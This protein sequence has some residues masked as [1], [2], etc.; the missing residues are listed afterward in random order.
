MKA[1]GYKHPLP[2]EDPDSLLDLEIPELRPSSRDLLVEIKAVSV[3]P[4]DTKVRARVQ[5]ENG[6]YKILGYDAAGVVRGMGPEAKLFKPGDEVWYAGSI[7]RQG[8]NAQLHLVDERIVGPKPRT[9][10]FGASA[11]LPLTT[12][13]AW[14][15]LFD[16]L[17]VQI[18]KPP[19]AGSILIIGGSG[20][21][22]LI[23][24]QLARK[25]IGLTIISTSSAETAQ[26]CLQLGAHFVVDYSRPLAAQLKSIGIPEVNYMACLTASDHYFPGIVEVLAPQGKIGMID[27]PKTLDVVP[28]KA[29]AASLHWEAMFTRSTFQTPDMIAQHNLLTEVSKLVDEGLIHTTLG[30]V[31][32]PINAV[33]LKQA[34]KFVESGRAQGKLVLVGFES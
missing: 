9:L 10:D 7:I 14:E 16:R 25:L 33:N 19:D 11:A 17:G 2:I 32:G 26:R 24:T 27:D 5:P 23:L 30:R 20:G 28:L 3:N 4:V 34:H 31:L 21:V 15:L 6:E 13:T 8:T 12:I 18:G 22:G 1:V 29:K